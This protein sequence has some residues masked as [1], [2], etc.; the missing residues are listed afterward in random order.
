MNIQF[1]CSSCGHQLSVPASAV[2]KKARC[3]KCSAIIEI[4]AQS[5]VPAGDPQATGASVTGGSGSGSD[6]YQ[7]RPPENP[8]AYSDPAFN[9]PAAASSPYSA[10][11]QKPA[12]DPHNPY[13]SPTMGYDEQTTQPIGT[14]QVRPTVIDFNDVFGHAWN[15]YLQNLGIV[16]GAVMLAYVVNLVVGWVFGFINNIAAMAAGDED[17]AIIVALFVQFVAYFAQIAISTFVNIGVWRILLDVGKG[18]NVDFGKIF[19]GA[20]LFLPMYGATLL[21]YLMVIPATTLLIVPG[22]ILL[23]FFGQFHYLM[24]DQKVGVFDSFSRSVDITRGNRGTLLGIYA[25]SLGIAI[26]CFITCIPVGM[27]FF[28]PFVS[29]LW[30]VAYLKMTGQ[31]VAKVA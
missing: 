14:G 19:S 2:G 23:L 28:G 25:A 6:D 9:N 15:L 7:M 18:N 4:P 12:V 3:P 27:I 17:A 16:L 5:P 26:A 13:A 21:W 24:V 11:P 1:P 10:A 8:P 29:L 31:P 22:V 20:D 30:V